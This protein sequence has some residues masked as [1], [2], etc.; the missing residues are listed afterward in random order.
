MQVVS[1]MTMTAA[2][3]TDEPAAFSES[4][5]MFAARIFSAGNTYTEEPPGITA[6]S[7]RPFFTPPAISSRSTNGMPIGHFVVARLC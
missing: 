6:L 3:P 5:S 4:K 2:E 1:S 7:L